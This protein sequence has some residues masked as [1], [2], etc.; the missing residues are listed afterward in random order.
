MEKTSGTMGTVPQ[1]I[2]TELSLT[3]CTVSRR[4]AITSGNIPLLGVLLK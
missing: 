1:L 4:V 2:M 3:M